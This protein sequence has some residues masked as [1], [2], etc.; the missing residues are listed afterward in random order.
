MVVGTVWMKLR[1]YEVYSLKDKRSIVKSLCN[2]SRNK[3]NISIAEVDYH[4]EHHWIGL[5]VA[6]VDRKSVV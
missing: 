3:F 1:I 6:C 4:D 2:K 5:G